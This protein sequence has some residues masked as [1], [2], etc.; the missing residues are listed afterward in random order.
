M[1]LADTGNYVFRDFLMTRH[2]VFCKTPCCHLCEDYTILSKNC[3]G[4]SQRAMA[5]VPSVLK[6]MT[7]GWSGAGLR[8][9]SPFSFAPGLLLTVRPVQLRWSAGGLTYLM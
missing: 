5:C 2:W 6:S 7:A 8:Q 1:L 9:T 4:Q 3:A